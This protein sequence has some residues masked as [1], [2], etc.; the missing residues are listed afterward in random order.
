VEWLAPCLPHTPLLSLLRQVTTCRTTRPRLL[1]VVAVFTL[2]IVNQNSMPKTFKLLSRTD[3]KLDNAT[4][5]LRSTYILDAIANITSQTN[6][7]VTIL[8]QHQAP[9]LGFDTETLDRF[10]SLFKV[11]S[12]PAN[13][14]HKRQH[15]SWINFHVQSSM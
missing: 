4:V 9:I 10:P 12:L 13:I 5:A 8:D 2:I 15:Q 1:V 14:N 11:H 3:E 6:P 7:N